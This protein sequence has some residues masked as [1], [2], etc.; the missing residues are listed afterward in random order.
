[1][2]LGAKDQVVEAEDFADILE[3]FAPGRG[4]AVA[5]RT[6]LGYSMASN[7]VCRSCLGG[8]RPEYI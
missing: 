4:R 6:A 8:L 2:S 3:P 7:L 5:F 1:M